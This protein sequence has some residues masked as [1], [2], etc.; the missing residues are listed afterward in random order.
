M[1]TISYVWLSNGKVNIP[2]YG[3]CRRNPK[4]LGLN[5]SYMHYAKPAFIFT[6]PYYKD[7]RKTSMFE[8]I[9]YIADHP[10]STRDDILSGAKIDSTW[11]QFFTALKAANIAAA[12]KGRYVLT[13]YGRAYVNAV[14]RGS[15]NWWISDSAVYSG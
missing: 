12:D 10:L 2:M 1:S 13:E 4:E 9:E 14:R 6:R 11:T 8:A 15:R 5:S 3:I 7:G